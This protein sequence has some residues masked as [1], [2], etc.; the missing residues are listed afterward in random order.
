MNGY[1]EPKRADG[2]L[3]NLEHK[4]RDAAV[5]VEDSVHAKRAVAHPLDDPVRPGLVIDGI[6]HLRFPLEP[7]DVQLVE[8]VGSQRDS[9]STTVT[10][11]EVAT[12][13]PR[14]DR[15]LRSTIKETCA[16]IRPLE[17]GPSTK[18]RLDS[19]TVISSK[20]AGEAPIIWS[21]LM[22]PC[23]HALLANRCSYH[24]IE[25]S[26]SGRVVDI[27]IEGDSRFKMTSVVVYAGYDYFQVAAPKGGLV[28]FLTYRLDTPE[29]PLTDSV[30]SPHWVSGV[31]PEMRDFFAEWRYSL[32]HGA[33]SD[34]V[35]KVFLVYLESGFQDLNSE[36]N[37]LSDIN[38]RL[39]GHLVSP[40]KAY[41]FRWFIGHVTHEISCEYELPVGH[42]DYLEERE[43]RKVLRWRMT[44]NE[45]SS[46]TDWEIC[47]PD[48]RPLSSWEGKNVAAEVKKAWA[49]DGGRLVKPLMDQ[50]PDNKEVDCVHT[51]VSSDVFY[52]RK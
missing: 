3:L 45:R 25:V 21:R 43:Y 48:G 26:Y 20:R 8:G 6:G 39:I 23:Q 33:D 35:P 28:T 27:N 36:Y 37:Q 12:S 16:L 50:D 47:K 1:V 38:A 10:A 18:I 44:S 19:F 24:R 29:L 5:K 41:G 30:P 7:R 4:F 51:G 46:E 40:A 52:F 9:G 2:G 49:T 34:Q 17:I 22:R 14:W 11:S 32:K 13:N 15:F 42:D 31:V